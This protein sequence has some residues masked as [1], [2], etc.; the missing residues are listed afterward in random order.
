MQ[1]HFIFINRRRFCDAVTGLLA[2][3]FLAKLP[4]GSKQSLKTSAE[5]LEFLVVN[6]W[7]LTRDDVVTSKLTHNVVRL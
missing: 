6:G 3:S 4:F 1:S 7:V 2:S 5:D